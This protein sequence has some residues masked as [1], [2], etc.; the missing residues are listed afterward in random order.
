MQGRN[1]DPDKE[2]GL[3]DTEGEWEEGTN[4]ESITGTYTLP[5]VK[6]VSNG[7]LL[8]PDGELSWVLCDDLGAGLGAGLGGRLE[9]EGTYVHL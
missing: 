6:Q 3:V 1:R 9:K 8:A 5:W 7:K 2:N 4:G